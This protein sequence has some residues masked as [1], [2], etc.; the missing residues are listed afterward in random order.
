MPGNRAPGFSPPRWPRLGRRPDA[1]RPVGGLP[2]PVLEIPYEWVYTLTRR[3]TT[4][5]NTATVT[6]TGGV[7]AYSTR[8]GGVTA[9]GADF[10][11]TLTT[12]LDV[13]AQSLA[14]HLTTYYG[15]AR[16]R[17]P[18]LTFNLYDRTDAE[19]LLLLNVGRFRRVR[20][21][22]APAAWPP[23][24]ANFTVEGFQH[25][26]AVDQRLLSWATAA[27]VGVSASAPGPWF[28]V[29]SSTVGGSDVIPF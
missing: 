5:V 29:D 6:Q 25:V 4:P 12:A 23:G 11:V 16:P 26:M 9:N 18:V 8:A 22:H 1:S 19:C 2:L 3:P 14:T 21:I 10:S 24:A 17:Q 13:D 27:L 7:T 28:R 20:I 15:T